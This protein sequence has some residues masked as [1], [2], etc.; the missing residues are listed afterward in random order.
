MEISNK[1]KKVSNSTIMKKK[2]DSKIMEKKSDSKKI[3]SIYISTD[4]PKRNV[5]GT[6]K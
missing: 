4:D 3:R 6:F 2:S 5:L 1:I